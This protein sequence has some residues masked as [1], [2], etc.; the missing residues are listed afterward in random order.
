MNKPIYK[1]AQLE[2][3]GLIIIVVIVITGLLIFTVYRITRPP[4]NVQKRY[5]NKE[6]ATNML[7]AMSNTHVP[8]CYNHSL[9]QLII[10]CSNRYSLM[11]CEDDQTSCKIVNKTIYN[12]LNKTLIAWD[13]SFNFSIIKTNTSFV[14][15]D[16]NSARNKVQGFEVFTSKTGQVEIT[17]DVCE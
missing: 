3:I 16:C 12:I 10:D 8:E 1:K 2:M 6:I 11:I 13:T 5:L 17:L 15:L 7:I 9:T 14:N 4:T